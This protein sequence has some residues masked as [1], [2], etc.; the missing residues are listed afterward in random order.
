MMDIYFLG[1]GTAIPAKQHAPAGVLVIANGLRLLLDIGPGTLSR[2]DLAGF[3]S[4]QMDLLLLT[5]FHPDHTLDLA[6]LLQVFN[7][8]PGASRSKAFPITGCRGLSDFIHQLF[9]LY[10]DVIPSNYELDMR[11][12][13]RDEFTLGNIKITTMPTGHTPES[14]AYRLDDSEHSLVYS[15]DASLHGEL[16]RLAKGADLLISECSFPAGWETE[17]H[18]NADGVAAIA[19]QSG[20]KSL[21]VTHS[22]PPAL[23]VDLVSQIHHHYQGK[24]QAAFD[25]LHLSL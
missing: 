24:V 2:L 5:H 13:Y 6:T 22:Y 25:G 9:I 18:L 4:D 1:T 14:V 10:P 8:T 17:D 15:G 23:D 21:I 19:Q 16:A 12:V 11:E 7:Y 20:V 3:T